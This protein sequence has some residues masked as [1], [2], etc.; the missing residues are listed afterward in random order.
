[1]KIDSHW[2]DMDELGGLTFLIISSLKFG[3]F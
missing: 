2:L 1:M 3:T